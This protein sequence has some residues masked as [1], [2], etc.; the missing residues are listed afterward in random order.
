VSIHY[1]GISKLHVGDHEESIILYIIEIR[2]PT[3]IKYIDQPGYQRT[4]ILYIII[5][6]IYLL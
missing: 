2:V 5:I 4:G 1:L 3:Y 6:M